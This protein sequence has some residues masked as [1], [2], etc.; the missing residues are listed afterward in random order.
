MRAVATP[1]RRSNFPKGRQRSDRLAAYL[2]ISPAMAL[3]IVFVIAPVFG[4]IALSF[5]QWDLISPPTAAG[6]S[7]FTRLATD[8]NLRGSL[9]NT[10][11]FTFWSIVLHVGLGTALALLVNRQMAGITRY[12]LRTTYFFPFLISWAAVSLIWEYAFDPTFGVFNF[13][14]SMIGLPTGWLISKSLALPALILVDLW[15]T[16]GFSFVVIFAGLQTI[17]RHLNEAAMVDGAGAWRRFWYVTLPMLSPTLF[18]VTVINFIGA[19]QIFDPM[20]IMTRGGPARATE[21]VVQYL[22]DTAF[23]DFQMGYAS[24]IALVVFAVILIATLVQ[25]R[26]RGRWVHEE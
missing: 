20:F 26:I 6:F 24:A 8:A 4:S 22:Y 3:F 16:L 11:V 10:F 13:Y 23:R 25:F 1:A 14:G 12:F 21:S 2:F 9:A 17:P 18:F 15:H 7:N 19:F 5:V